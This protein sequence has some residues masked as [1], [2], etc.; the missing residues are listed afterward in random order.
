ML[1][2]HSQALHQAE[3]IL[4]HAFIVTNLFKQV[5]DKTPDETWDGYVDGHLGELLD[6]LC[7]L[8]YE[9]DQ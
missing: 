6:A 3:A 7:D 8:E 5:R 1:S 2:K 4:D 9:V